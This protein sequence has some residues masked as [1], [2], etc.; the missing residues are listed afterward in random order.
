MGYLL[1]FCWQLFLQV[2]GDMCLK[3]V[4][5]GVHKDIPIQEGEVIELEPR[6][7][8]ASYSYCK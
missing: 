4:E 3:I 7:K 8:S 2:K 6:S 5:K 1:V